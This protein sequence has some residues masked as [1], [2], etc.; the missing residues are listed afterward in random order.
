[1]KILII[2]NYDSFTFNLYHYLEE[3]SELV[4]VF[5]ND[6][7]DLKNVDDYDAIVLSPGPGLPQDAGICIDV[8]KSYCHTKK[9]LGVCLGHQAIAMAFGGRLKNLSTV[10]HG[11][12]RLTHLT[13]PKDYIYKEIPEAF[14]CGRYHSW[15]VDKNNLPEELTVT[16]TDDNGEIM[17]LKHR[18]FDVRGV[19]FH[20]ESILT[21]YGK[22]LLKNWLEN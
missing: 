13:Q 14:S 15:V 1:M 11:V 9:I 19:Q 21:D 5:R 20:P 16:A 12:S 6:G 2:D 8:I 7:I 10:L 3:I 4:H 18:S 17:S 22:R